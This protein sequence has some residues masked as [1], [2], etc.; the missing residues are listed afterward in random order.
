MHD[1][2]SQDSIKGSPLEETSQKGVYLR[3]GIVMGMTQ[4]N[5][6]GNK[7]GR[8]ERNVRFGVSLHRWYIH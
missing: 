4:Y 2:I 7:Y 8:K 1:S 3:G 5:F 6:C